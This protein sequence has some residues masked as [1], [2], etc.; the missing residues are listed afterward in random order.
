MDQQELGRELRLLAAETLALQQILSCVLYELKSG[1][2]ELAAVIGR[3]FD[4]AAS[5]IEN[6]AIKAGKS[7]PPE[8]LVKALRVVEELRVAALGRGGKPKS[9]V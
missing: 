2:A 1:N 6:M 9:I 4:Q 8:H 5:Q 3:G 7:V